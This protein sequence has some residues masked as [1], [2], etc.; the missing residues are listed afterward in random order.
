MVMH[1]YSPPCSTITPRVIVCISC[2]TR[3]RKASDDQPCG[4]YVQAGLDC[5]YCSLSPK[6]RAR[7]D[8]D[9]AHAPRL[10]LFAWNVG[11]R[12]GF[13]SESAAASA[14]ALITQ[15][16]SLE[17]TRRLA[18]IFFEKVDPCYK[19][20]R[21]DSILA[22][23]YQNWSKEAINPAEQLHDAGGSR[24]IPHSALI[25]VPTAGIES[26]PEP[27]F[28]NLLPLS[29]SL[30]PTGPSQQDLP[31]LE[32]TLTSALDLIFHESSLILVQCNLMLCIFRRV[33]TLNAHALL[34]SRL[35][36]R[37][38][39]LADCG[40]CA[41]RVMVASACPL[42]QTANAPSRWSILIVN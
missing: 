40:L 25:N 16:V 5:Q 28:L 32:Q 10:Q 39:S 29:E 37:V 7:P 13:V 30:D 41:A 34:S 3:K 4:R 24:A 31:Q 19:F 14:S 33:R 18:S 1:V 22:P 17:E 35:P 26:F 21:R 20:F 42:Q 12:P 2:H 36:H 23:I 11:Q 15:I 38:L 8:I 6:G 27:D 9:L